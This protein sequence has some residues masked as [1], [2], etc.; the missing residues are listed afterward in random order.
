MV[1]QDIV[2]GILR[3]L[4]QVRLLR[5]EGGVLP[6][7]VAGQQDPAGALGIRGE[8]I[9]RTGLP[10]LDGRPGMGQPRDDAHEHRQ[11]HFFRQTEGVGHHVI[12]LLL[13]GR[14]EDG[15][16]RELPVEAGVL[17]V[18]GGMHGRI[19]R[20]NDHQAALHAGDAGVHECIGTDVHA[21]VLHAHQGALPGI[22][23]AQGRLHGRFF[24]RAPAAPNPAF[25]R[26]RIALDEFGDLG[27]RR[28]RICIHPG[29]SGM[30]RPQ[31]KR[32]VSKQESLIFH[33]SNTFYKL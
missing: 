25:P 24:V 6:L 14:L 27:R 23:H 12:A 7:G 28:S 29:Q 8:R 33:G 1:L 10:H 9:L 19:V 17:L 30:Q 4:E 32:L 31:G 20:R 26:E 15:N 11:P 18:L 3:A 5:H 21:H 2:A 22:G 16:H 13:V